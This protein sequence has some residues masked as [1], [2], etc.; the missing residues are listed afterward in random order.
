MTE[1]EYLE[2]KLKLSKRKAKLLKRVNKLLDLIIW[3]SRRKISLLNEIEQI[4]IDI[5]SLISEYEKSVVSEEESKDEESE[6][7]A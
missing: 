4:D 3:A 2:E 7:T 6:L 1:L 5:L